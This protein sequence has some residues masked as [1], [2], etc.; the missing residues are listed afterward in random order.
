[1]GTSLV[2]QWLRHELPMQGAGVP[3]LVR[4]LDLTAPTKR[5]HMATEDPACRNE[6]P[7]QPNK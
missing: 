3:S 6:D 2:I 5:S 4:E 7:V 1:M